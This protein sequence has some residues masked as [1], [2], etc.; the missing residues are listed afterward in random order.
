MTTNVVQRTTVVS[1]TVVAGGQV[2][3]PGYVE[4]DRDTVVDHGSLTGPRDMRAQGSGEHHDLGQSI[5]VPGFVDMHV[6]GGG[7]GAFTSESM[8]EVRLAAA[9]H[10]A[11]GTTALCASLVSAT[12]PVLEAQVARL[13]DLVAQ[14]ELL[15]IHLEGPWLA[16][17]KRGAHDPGVLRDPDLGEIRRLIDVGQGAIRMVT[18]APELP[19]AIEAIAML[20]EHGVVAAVGHTDATYDQTRAAIDAGATVGTHLFNAMRPI[21]HRE[22][23]PVVALTEDPRVVVE[24]IA[25]GVHLHP[26]MVEQVR[27][28]VGADRMALVTDAMVATGMPDGQYTL[29]TLEVTVADGVAR[30]THGDSIAGGTGTTDAL[31]R[32]AAAPGDIS[33]DER[34][35]DAVR[36]TSAVPV[37]A[38]GLAPRDL[39]I[40]SPADL[41]ALTP[42]L[43]VD[44][45]MAGG[46]WVDT[47]SATM[48]S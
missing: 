13:T 34:L 20:R 23:G 3:R 40:G 30:L 26:T 41:V 45:V 10:R 8:T 19:G 47:P 16:P 31:F 22:P 21:G 27:H 36:M 15:G 28:W 42:A 29:G 6:H 25:D 11:Y 9:T 48:E 46:V 38:L 18:I 4:M 35:L 39:S 17:S 33:D 44:K 43:H 12:A 2:H 37:R 5:V 7:G 1:D 14:G 24:V 32:A